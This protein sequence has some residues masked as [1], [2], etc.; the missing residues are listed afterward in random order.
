MI[1]HTN[2]SNVLLTWAVRIRRSMFFNN[3]PTNVSCTMNNKFISGVQHCFGT[4][5]RRITDGWKNERD[6]VN[7]PIIICFLYLVCWLHLSIGYEDNDN[8][9]VVDDAANHSKLFSSNNIKFSNKNMRS[10]VAGKNST[11]SLSL[12][13]SFVTHTRTMRVNSPP[14][15]SVCLCCLRWRCTRV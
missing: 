14:S 11:L 12:S 4:C 1:L 7:V 10:A 5:C 6:Q 13:A 3:N 2:V 9:D 8:D 15:G